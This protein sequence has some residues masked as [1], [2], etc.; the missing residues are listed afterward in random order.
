[1]TIPSTLRTCGLLLAL[2]GLSGTAVL[3]GCDK[4]SGAATMGVLSGVTA[5][6]IAKAAGANDTE[7]AL[8][9]LGV[10]AVAATA[11]YLIMDANEKANEAQRRQAEAAVMRE[12]QMASQE[13]R[14]MAQGSQYAAVPV[15]GGG[16]L[17]VDTR[18]N[19]PINGGQIYR[20]QPQGGQAQAA[21]APGQT[22]EVPVDQQQSSTV[23]AVVLAS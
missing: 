23:K 15:E 8:I 14:P 9:G 10:G 20:T 22:V 21:P 16:F 1:M 5:G 11:T 2:A 12:R 3:T 6:V 18:T 17:V 7:A 4:T 13:Q 19:Q